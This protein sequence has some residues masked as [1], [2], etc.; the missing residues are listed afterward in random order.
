MRRNHPVR[1]QVNKSTPDIQGDCCLPKQHKR[2]LAG[3]IREKLWRLSCQTP[4]GRE[5]SQFLRSR[6]C[7]GMGFGAP[8]AGSGSASGSAG[9][10][11]GRIS[12]LLRPSCSSC[13]ETQEWGTGAN[14]LKGGL[15]RR[16]VLAA[17]G[18]EISH[19]GAVLRSQARGRLFPPTRG[20]P[21]GSF[22]PFT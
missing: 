21:A 4:T 15:D 14:S 20:A 12:A 10:S 11:P 22:I 3:V 2:S 6:K 13:C 17:Q 8:G 16:A 9:A 19:H 5:I 7:M 1:H 18:L